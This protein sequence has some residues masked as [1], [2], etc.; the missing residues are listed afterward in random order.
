MPAGSEGI[1][2]SVGVGEALAAKIDKKVTGRS[3]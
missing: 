2:L 3:S 1:G